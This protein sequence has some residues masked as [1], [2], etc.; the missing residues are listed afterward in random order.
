MII[1]SKLNSV[2]INVDSNTL[3]L[4]GIKP[5]DIVKHKSKRQLMLDINGFLEK[6]KQMF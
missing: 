4:L 1:D 5:D 2:I 3:K 6:S